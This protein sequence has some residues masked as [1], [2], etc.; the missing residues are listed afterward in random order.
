MRFT[1][2]QLTAR[3][4]L[5][6]KYNSVQVIKDELTVM[7]SVIMKEHQ[8]FVMAMSKRVKPFPSLTLFFQ[9][10]NLNCWNFFE[11]KVLSYLIKCNCS[12]NLKTKM[13]RYEHDM[14]DFKQTTTVKNFIKYGQPRICPKPRTLPPRFKKLVLTK[15]IDPDT[16]TLAEL[17]GIRMKICS[18][19][20]LSECALQLYSIKYNCIIVEWIFPEEITEILSYFLSDTNSQELLQS[21][22]VERII[23]DE[24][25]LNS[26]SS[27]HNIVRLVLCSDVASLQWYTS[28]IKY[29]RMECACREW[30]M[31]EQKISY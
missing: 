13:V 12:D 10:L 9:Y 30:S 31:H 24:D 27:L 25:S 2:L 5:E 26:V 19:L 1:Q 7:P 8:K 16:Y 14:Q 3:H 11:Y 18:Q 20:K 29:H 21:H 4:E 15:C 23:I 22:Y 17:D 6:L 28:T